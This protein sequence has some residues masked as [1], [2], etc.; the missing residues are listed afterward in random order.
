MKFKKLFG[1]DFIQ[2][3]SVCTVASLRTEP[4]LTFQVK[5]TF[6]LAKI[7]IILLLLIKVQLRLEIVANIK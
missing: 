6:A 3:A 1:W 7:I 5:Y 4:R 2:S